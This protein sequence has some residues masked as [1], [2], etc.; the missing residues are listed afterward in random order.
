MNLRLHHNSVLKIFLPLLIILGLAW[1]CHAMEIQAMRILKMAVYGPGLN[2]GRNLGPDQINY[3]I[4]SRELLRAIIQGIDFKREH[5]CSEVGSL[6]N[7]IIY[8]QF[9]DGNV[10]RYQ[11]INNWSNFSAYGTTSCCY[12]V[13]SQV[14]SI[15]KD[16]AQ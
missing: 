11:L 6:M 10:A 2:V 9:V 15:L 14:R 1:P 13:N 4:S 8:I 7:A 12:Q 5:N 16:Y 3:N